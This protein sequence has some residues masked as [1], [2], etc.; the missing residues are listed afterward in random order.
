MYRTRVV[1]SL[2][3]RCLGCALTFVRKNAN[4]VLRLRSDLSFTAVL[5]GRGK[6]AGVDVSAFGT[7]TV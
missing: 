3:W 7:A 4:H 1:C 5:L 2:Q 6:V